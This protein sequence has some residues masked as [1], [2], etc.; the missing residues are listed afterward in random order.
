M[1]DPPIPDFTEKVTH[2]P[3][4]QRLDSAHPKPMRSVIGKVRQTSPVQPASA[5]PS[6]PKISDSPDL[7]SPKIIL[8][9][10][11]LTELL[12]NAFGFSEFR[13]NQET[14]CQAVTAG[15]DALLVMPIG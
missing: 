6:I 1:Y 11:S 12:Q 15:G 8:N 7:P 5:V 13:P 2:G 4:M 3:T 10:A 14:V 9:T